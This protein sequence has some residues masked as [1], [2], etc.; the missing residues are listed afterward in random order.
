MHLSVTASNTCPHTPKIK[1]NTA[2][3]GKSAREH[4]VL[5]LFTPTIPTQ[6]ENKLMTELIGFSIDSEFIT[7]TARE[8]LY[9]DNDLRSAL[10]I[11]NTIEMSDDD[12][13]ISD[14]D[15]LI[16][17]LKILDGQLDLSGIYP[18]EPIKCTETGSSGKLLEHFDKLKDRIDELEELHEEYME[19]L[20]EIQRTVPRQYLPEINRKMNTTIFPDTDADDIIESITT[21]DYEYGWLS[22]LAYSQK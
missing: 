6:G 21:C 13:N 17:R 20:T 10:N 22:P 9:Q 18:K 12:G 15:A 14:D 2:I 7:R 3:C 8:K 11:L 5:F 1:Q 16:I 4:L 19:T